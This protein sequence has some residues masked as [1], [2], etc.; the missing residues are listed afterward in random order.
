ME[1]EILQLFKS[2]ET[3][4]QI[5]TKKLMLVDIKYIHIQTKTKANIKIKETNILNL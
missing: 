1:K 2:N 3:V 5:I 4:P